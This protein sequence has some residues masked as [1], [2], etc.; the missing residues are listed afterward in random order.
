VRARLLIDVELESTMLPEL[1]DAI[2]HQRVVFVELP[3]PLG[4][5]GGRLMGAQPVELEAHA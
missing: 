5:M 1:A 3:T 4:N 2:A